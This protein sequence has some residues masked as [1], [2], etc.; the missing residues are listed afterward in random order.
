[1][2]LVASDSIKLKFLAFLFRVLLL[3]FLSQPAEKKKAVTTDR[4]TLA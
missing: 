2:N 3:F 4:E 1:M